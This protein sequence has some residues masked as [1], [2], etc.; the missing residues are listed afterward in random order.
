MDIDASSFPFSPRPTIDLYLRR[1]KEHVAYHEAGH[2]AMA[3]HHGCPVRGITIRERF[4]DTWEGVTLLSPTWAFAYGPSAAIQIA[5][6]GHAAEEL[7]QKGTL[8]IQE[9]G[10]LHDMSVVKEIARMNWLTSSFL[11]R[12][13]HEASALFQDGKL[14]ATLHRIAQAILDGKTWDIEVGNIEVISDTRPLRLNEIMFET[15]EEYEDYSLK[16]GRKVSRDNWS[17]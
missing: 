1:H 13:I 2:A 17:F 10:A 16:L 15:L 9:T 6:A 14:Q 7:I 11:D 3:L 12:C 5:Y 8:S 4:R